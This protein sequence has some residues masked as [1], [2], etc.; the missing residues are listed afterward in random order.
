M[1]NTTEYC[2]FKFCNRVVPK[3]TVVC[4]YCG[5]NVKYPVKPRM[6]A[7]QSAS[8]KPIASAKPAPKENDNF[9]FI[10]EFQGSCGSCGKLWFFN[11]KDVKLQQINALKNIGKSMLT[12]GGSMLAGIIPNENVTEHQRCPSCGSRATKI[13]R[14]TNKRYL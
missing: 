1:D 10:E 5:N 2:Q 3:G 13:Q 14:V 8:Y 6:P 7:P 4:P 12:L 9:E 11:E